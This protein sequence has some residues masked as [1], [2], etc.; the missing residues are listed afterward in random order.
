M[1]G[2]SKCLAVCCSKQAGIDCS[3]SCSENSTKDSPGPNSL[4]MS[5]PTYHPVLY[6]LRA[7]VYGL[8]SRELRGL[9]SVQTCLM[10]AKH[11]SFDPLLP[12]FRHPP[13]GATPARQIEYCSSSLI[14]T[15]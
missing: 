10:E 2:R 3:S 5:D 6:W 4:A 14:T 15:S 9:K 7:A 11:S 12:T 8:R 13:G 1:A